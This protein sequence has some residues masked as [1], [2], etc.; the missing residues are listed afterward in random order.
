[1]SMLRYP[2]GVPV[3][4]DETHFMRRAYSDIEYSAYRLTPIHAR[5]PTHTHTHAFSALAHRR[6]SVPPPPVPHRR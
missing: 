2:F 6:L 4:S 3:Y 1:M 5:A